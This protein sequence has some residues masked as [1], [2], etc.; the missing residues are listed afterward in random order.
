MGQ[1]ILYYGEESKIREK[2]LPKSLEKI[3]NYLEAH[4]SIGEVRKL[5]SS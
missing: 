4:Y 5:I 2:A 3:N 1:L